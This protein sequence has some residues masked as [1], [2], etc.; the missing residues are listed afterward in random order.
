MSLIQQDGS[1]KTADPGAS[2][3][4]TDGFKL[5]HALILKGNDRTKLRQEALRIASSLICLDPGPG[6]QPCG[7]C[8][9]C[10]QI[11]AMAYPYWFELVPQ[12]AANLIRISQIRELQ[13]RL[14]SKAGEG[15]AKVAVLV[16]AHRMREES[17]NCLL[18]T[19][20][21]PLGDTLL[22]LLT[23]R[24][25]D[26][27]PTVRSRCRIRDIGVAAPLPERADL[28]LTIDAV[29]DFEVRGYLGVFEKAAFVEGSRKKALPAFFG[30]LEYLLR[31]G[32]VGS[33]LPS[34]EV[35]GRDVADYNG[36]RL[37]ASGPELIEALSQVW[38]AGYLLERNVNP[39]LIVENLFLKLRKLNIRVAEGGRTFD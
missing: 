22:L 8:A 31:D 19:L 21:E 23:D 1:I 39:L 4:G 18:K 20:E 7:V 15:Q 11:A 2:V 29:R 3:A 16:D 32:L 10:R 26:L 5:S 9:H 28:E 24:P 13:S 30:A 6:R 17:Q 14:V 37:T 27:L 38:R 34:G 25:Q 33:L 35:S 36:P 12:G